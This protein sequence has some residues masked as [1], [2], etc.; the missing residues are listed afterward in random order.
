M[1]SRYNTV[2]V[3]MHNKKKKKS[4]N[5]YIVLLFFEIDNK[6]KAASFNILND[7]NLIQLS[8]H[9]YISK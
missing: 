7:V 8:N 5:T 6:D 1:S 2:K 9:G 4:F 3:S